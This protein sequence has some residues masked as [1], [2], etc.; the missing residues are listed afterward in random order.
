RHHADHMLFVYGQN[1]PWGAERFRLGKG[2][3][4]SS[5]GPQVPPAVRWSYGQGRGAPAAS[6]RRRDRRGRAEVVPGV[7]AVIR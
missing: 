1:D 4:D 3:R 6:G 7:G 5:A 2:A